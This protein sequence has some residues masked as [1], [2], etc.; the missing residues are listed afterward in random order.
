M[1]MNKKN[2]TYKIHLQEVTLKDGTQG[3]RSIEFDFDNHDNILD[4]LELVKDRN[5]FQSKNEDIEFVV[6]LKLFGEVL[7]KNRN[8]PLFTELAPQFAAFMKKLKST[9]KPQDLKH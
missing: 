8:H 1:H 7:L 2:N 4:I 9:V 3:T 5:L 6:G